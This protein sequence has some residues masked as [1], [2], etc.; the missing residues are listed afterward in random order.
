[1]EK[2]IL[3]YGRISRI[4]AANRNATQESFSS[5]N[6]NNK[7]DESKRECLHQ[8]LRPLSYQR[9][10]R[11]YHANKCK[12]GLLVDSTQ[13]VKQKQDKKLSIHQSQSKHKVIYD[14]PMYNPQFWEY[15][16]IGLDENE[17]GKLC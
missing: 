13:S 16:T 5:H 9:I 15:E 14:V 2:P 12:D 6:N 11:R 1:M 8:I 10:Q 3:S 4:H 17:L 7:Y